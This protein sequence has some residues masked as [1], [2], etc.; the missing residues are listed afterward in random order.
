ML[1]YDY[2]KVC[3]LC[4]IKLLFLCISLACEC[5]MLISTAFSGRL[6]GTRNR[7]YD[8]FTVCSVINYITALK[9]IL[10]ECSK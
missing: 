8:T 7:I 5:G 2:I 10:F 9:M 1:L 6:G 4:S 3:E